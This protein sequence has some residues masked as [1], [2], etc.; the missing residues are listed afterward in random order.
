MVQVSY[1][2]VYIQEVP[3]GVRTI[4]PV[5]TSTG[6]FVGFF[7]EGPSNQAV[8]INGM[9][10]FDR[11]FGG[12]DKR[13]EA[14]YAISQFFRNGGTKAEVVRVVNRTV[15]AGLTVAAAASV[16]LRSASGGTN[17]LTVTAA[18]EGAWSNRLRVAIDHSPRDAQSFHMRV[19]RYDAGGAP[20]T[21]ERYLNL[22]VDPT[23]GQ[24]FVRVV[25]ESS[26]LVTVAH[27]AFAAGAPF[28]RPAANGSEGVAVD[29]I[30]NFVQLDT[31][32]DGPFP[33]RLVV[34]RKSGADPSPSADVVEVVP[35]HTANLDLAAPNTPTSMR[36]LR[37]AIESA[38]RAAR[39]TADATRPTD[40]AFAGATVELVEGGGATP[41][42]LVI[43]TNAGRRGYDPRE[44]VHVVQAG[45][46]LAQLGLTG[47]TAFNVQEYTL[48]VADAFDH[49][50]QAAAGT[51]GA[52][53]TMPDSTVAVEGAAQA[54]A[55][56]TAILG[57]EAAKTGL[58]ALE[59]ADLFNILC[60]PLAA[61]LPSLQ[62]TA[63]VSEAL[64]YC[65][66]RRAFMI[67]DFPDR[68]DT[69]QEVKDWIDDNAGFRNRSVATYFPRLRIPDPKNDF[70]PR[71]VGASG[72]VAGIYARTDSTR[73][74]WKAPAGLDAALRGVSELG[75][76]MTDA[77]NGSINPI[78][79]NALRVF[80]IHGQVVWGARTLDG[81]DV[82]AS[83]WKYV[84]VRRT[85]LMIE[86]S[87]FRGTKWVVFEPNDEPTWAKVRQ[88]VG[89]FMTGLFRQGAFQ[90]S[91]PDKAFYVKCDGETTTANDRN[92][93]I[94]NIEVGFAPLKPA[95][96]VVI[97]IQQIP[98]VD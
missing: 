29:E 72:T 62:M 53:G 30:G 26:S 23:S 56:A 37:R 69:I 50:A 88:N 81:A 1:P 63:V 82:A 21:V 84:S 39:P 71:S 58:Y 40:A 77:E 38:I 10:D 60:L 43:R 42:Q 61:K 97:K 70:L 2:G 86:E 17:V 80:P 95:E 6:A 22:S 75:F 90:G 7:A 3:S 5:A 36:G 67:L 51:V 94:V 57:N 9:A 11:T 65:E 55:F 16:T 35:E 4:T 12:V 79:V 64:T 47:T 93:G 52:D 14:S 85:A 73:G 31:G 27:D 83:E 34:R 66:R 15:A 49:R 41:F 8:E 18:S 19:I 25:N 20:V 28:A 89:A 44:F 98:D 24:Y 74:V 32:A 78:A 91:T 54:S 87:L 76:K 96:F 13:S 48:G 92:L 68:I 33:I 46:H 59:D 45:A